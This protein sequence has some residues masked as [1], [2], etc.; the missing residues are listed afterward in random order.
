MHVDVDPEEAP[1]SLSGSPPPTSHVTTGE[2]AKDATANVHVATTASAAAATN[3][4]V[5][6]PSAAAGLA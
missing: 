3:V 2:K 5:Q 6:S 1:M 4:T